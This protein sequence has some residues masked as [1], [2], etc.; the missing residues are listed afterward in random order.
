MLLLVFFAMS[1]SGLRQTLAVALTIIAFIYLMKNKRLVFFI[2]VGT[3]Y[4]FHNSA[5]IFLLV[6]FLKRIKINKKTGFIFYVISCFVFLGREWIASLVLY[7]APDKYTRYML[8]TEASY[9]NPLVIIVAMAIPIACLLFWPKEGESNND[10]HNTAMSMFFVMSCVNFVSYFLAMEINLFERITFYFM[11]YNSVLI[12]NVI[13]GIKSKEIRLIAK[14][15]C[16]VLPFFQ[17]IIAT[18]GGSLGI[19]NYKFFWE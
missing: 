5:I 18:P 4:F 15:A 1:M 6:F 17:F 3:S 19:D 8:M 7:V 12:P 9:V 13:Q 2:L 14:T 11:I 10:Q 16:V